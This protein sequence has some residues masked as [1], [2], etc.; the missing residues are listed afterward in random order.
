MVVSKVCRWAL[1]AVSFTAI[2]AATGCSSPQNFQAAGVHR[3]QNYQI[4]IMRGSESFNPKL[5]VFLNG[6]QA[7]M[8][9]R[10]NMFRDPGCQQTNISSWRCEYTT[11]YRGMELRVVEET[12]TTLVSNSLN[13]DVYLDGSYVQR[14]V[15]ALY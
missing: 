13:Y 10:V 6:E 8:V 4:E 2:F 5:F 3:G 9:E 7:M 11:D 1:A 12:N 15:A 14:V